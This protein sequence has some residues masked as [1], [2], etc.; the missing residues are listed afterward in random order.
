MRCSRAFD[1]IIAVMLIAA[2][3]AG[4][5]KGTD[6]T[7]ATEASTGIQEYLGDYNYDTPVAALVYEPVEGED[8]YG[9]QYREVTDADG[10]LASDNRVLIYF[11]S[12]MATELLRVTAGV[13][14]IAQASWGSVY[15]IMV[16]TMADTDLGTRYSIEQV[17]VFVMVQAGDEISRFDGYNY[18]EWSLD[19]V[20][21]WLEE[22]GVTMDYTRL[23]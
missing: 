7:G 17:P 9:I 11:Y 5:G 14:D 3:I 20:A 19:D 13:E 21:E 4:C 22:N 12:S 18:D 23:Q 10:L 2:L 16:D 1:L 6:E 8:E 15:V